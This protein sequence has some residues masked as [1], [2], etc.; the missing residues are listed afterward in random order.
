MAVKIEGDRIDTVEKLVATGIPVMGHLGFTPQSLHQLGGYKVQGRSDGD[1]I[2]AAALALENAG[3]F[4]IVLELVPAELAA[5]ITAELS[6]PTVGIGAGVDC[7]SQVLV[8]TD[9]MGITKNPPKLAKAY[10]NLRKEM[11]D[12]TKEW[13][14]DVVASRFP[15]IDQS[16]K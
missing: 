12:A 1:A 15:G 2:L 10:R 4:A 5:R 14:S 8:W 9:L 6:I 3:A 7:D 13:A 11:A 16:F